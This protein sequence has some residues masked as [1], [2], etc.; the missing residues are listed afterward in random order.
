MLKKHLHQSTQLEHIKLKVVKISK[1]NNF[2]SLN[3]RY[4]FEF[5]Q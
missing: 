2:L 3:K 5:W 4:Y 1:C